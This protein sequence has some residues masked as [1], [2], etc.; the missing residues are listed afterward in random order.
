MGGGGGG[1]GSDGSGEGAEGSVEHGFE[2][3]GGCLGRWGVDRKRGFFLVVRSS[4]G[5]SREET[6]GKDV[7]LT[8]A[9]LV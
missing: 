5:S 7:T 1:E 8:V 2:W 9:W 4:A 3:E 6:G